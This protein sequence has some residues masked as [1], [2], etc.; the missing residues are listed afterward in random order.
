MTN[1]YP[2]PMTVPYEFV[3]TTEGFLDLIN[4]L[5]TA[6]VVA[7]D[8]E[9]EVIDGS[10]L[11]R[12]GPGPWCV[13]S[14]AARLGDSASPVEKLWVVDM[15]DIDTAAVA[16]PLAAIES[17]SWNASFERLVFERDGVY[18]ARWID[19]M[20]FQ[21]TLDQG[22]YLGNA[23]YTGLAAA[24]RKWL[25]VD[26][27]GKGSIQLS[28]KRGVPLTDEQKAYAGQ[29]AIVTLWL[30]D[31]LAAKVD[32]AGLRA[33]AMRECAAQNYIDNLK[34]NGLAFDAEG[35]RQELQAQQEAADAALAKLADLTSGSQITLF[36]PSGIPDWNPDSTPDVKRILN[37]YE[38]ERVSA[39]Q[40]RWGRRGA[41][42]LSTEDQADKTTLQLIGGEIVDVLLEYRARKKLISTYGESMLALMWDDGRFH[43]RYLQNLTNTGRLSSD[44]PNAQNM[45][46]E[47]KRYTRP[48]SKRRVLVCAD[49]SQAELRLLAQI[50]Q[51]AAMLGAFRDGQDL[52]V[53]TAGRMFNE[54]M[55]AL[56]AADPSK[57]SALRKK[58]KTLNFGI[59]YGLG[60]RSLALRLTV[61][62]VDTTVSEAKE[63]LKRYLEVYPQVAKWLDSRD[64]FV[65]SVA[66]TP[67]PVDWTATWELFFKFK[68]CNAAYWKI[69]KTGGVPSWKNIAA[70]VAA[71]SYRTDATT[72]PTAEITPADA[73]WALSYK[74]PVVLA[75][76]QTPFEFESRTPGGRRR[77]F[78]VSTDAWL[79]SMVLIAGSSQKPLPTQVRDDWAE[80]NGQRPLRTSNG[81]PLSWGALKKR[82]EDKALKL[83][84]VRYVIDKMPSGAEFLMNKALEDCIKQKSNEFRNHP[85]QGGVGDVVLDA[86][87]LLDQR[88]GAID[89]AIGVQS[90]HDSIVVECDIADAP[91]VAQVVKAAMLEAMEAFCPDLPIKVDVDVQR[92][93]DAKVDTIESVEDEIASLSAKAPVAV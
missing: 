52:H 63:L 73:K 82:F 55:A 32:E 24:A 31:I 60:A 59:V 8:T 66:E 80:L 27:E 67:G 61:E 40:E 81:K 14:I 22:T 20:H 10:D 87:A 58:A 93:L 9:T 23:F 49:F 41:T 44:K 13:T 16:G 83:S 3:D 45:A 12:D 72:G 84:F 86:F 85:I 34:R 46:P 77:L 54:D 70:E 43:S 21:A 15:S 64:A 4:E 30:G 39:Y 29:D 2:D 36:G 68:P 7:I 28:Y 48:S 78:H 71:G 17:Y 38:P 33:T 90:V 37:K 18:I 91:Q 26:L 51:D 50:T 74:G 1:S 47:S 11:D 35:W 6:S 88:L 62:G 5:S 19:L 92:S 57:Y 25:N 75:D 65:R 79:S 42:E 53:V 89:G 56:E 76:R 69:R